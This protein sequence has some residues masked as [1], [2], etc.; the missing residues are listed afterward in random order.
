MIS[1][2]PLGK[3][4][5]IP[6]TKIL[7]D[8]SRECNTFAGNKSEQLKA[9]L[10]EFNRDV[11]KNVELDEFKEQLWKTENPVFME[12]DMTLKLEKHC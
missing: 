3:N 2:L 7:I 11:N 1:E 8:I 10:L 4:P 12:T 6:K 9:L 5:A